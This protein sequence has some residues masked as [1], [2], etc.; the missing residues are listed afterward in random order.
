MEPQTSERE[1]QP[2][3]TLGTWR[4]RIRRIN[5]INESLLNPLIL[6]IRVLNEEFG[7]RRAL[8]LK[9]A[10]PYSF[11]STIARREPAQAARDTYS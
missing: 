2:R 9:P 4:T 11:F 6:L 8:L 10:A 7:A 5:G 1:N 3:R